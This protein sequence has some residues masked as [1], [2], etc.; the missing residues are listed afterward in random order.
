MAFG[1]CLLLFQSGRL[2]IQLQSFVA[3][4]GI[5]LVRCLDTLIV[6]GILSSLGLGVDSIP[7]F[8]AKKSPNGEPSGLITQTPVRS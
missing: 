3:E 4:T 1:F 5:M 6:H 7:Y 8:K 2:A